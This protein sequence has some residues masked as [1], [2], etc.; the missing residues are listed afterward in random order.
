MGHMQK[1]HLGIKG[2]QGQREGM[3]MNTVLKD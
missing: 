1:L 2:Q 3:S